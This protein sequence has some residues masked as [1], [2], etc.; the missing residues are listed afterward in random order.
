ML[1]STQPCVWCRTTEMPPG[2]SWRTTDSG[3]HA[4]SDACETRWCAASTPMVIHRI[5][6]AVIEAHRELAEAKLSR[7]DET[8]EYYADCCVDRALAALAAVL[9]G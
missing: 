9:Q 7:A 2:S 4:C 1:Y 3:H 6:D 5:K 8:R